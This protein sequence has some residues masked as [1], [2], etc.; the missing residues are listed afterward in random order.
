M[1]GMPGNVLI[2][3]CGRRCIRT[4][5]VTSNVLITDRD[6]LVSY[7]AVLQAMR[8]FC[9][10]RTLADRAQALIKKSSMPGVRTKRPRMV[11]AWL[12]MR[13]APSRA[14]DPTLIAL[15]LSRS[16][17]A[18]AARGASWL[19]PCR[20]GFPPRKDLV[21]SGNS[22]ATRSK[23]SKTYADR[24]AISRYVCERKLSLASLQRLRKPS[25]RSWLPR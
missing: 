7:Q 13:R 5:T 6:G 24:L 4:R 17:L 8:R 21:L 20:D 14:G 11:S 9:E 16:R 15:D 19:H 18:V 3:D 1:Q 10:Q 2:I 12:P 23:F 25:S 22:S